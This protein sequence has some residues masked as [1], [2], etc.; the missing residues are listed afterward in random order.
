MWSKRRG[1]REP[2]PASLADEAEAYVHGRLHEL[3]ALT[4]ADRCFLDLNRLAH[5]SLA[6]VIR[7]ADEGSGRSRP[8]PLGD[9]AREVLGRITGAADLRA[10][11]R[12][13]LWPLEEDLLGNRSVLLRTPGCLVVLVRCALD[14]TDQHPHGS[15]RDGG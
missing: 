11:Q 6:D 10:V 1:A 12:R 5:G 2:Q 8:T 14:A 9:A 4:D 13:A 7:L 3:R 15:R